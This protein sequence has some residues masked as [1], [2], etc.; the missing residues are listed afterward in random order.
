MNWRQNSKSVLRTG[1]ACGI[2]KYLCTSLAMN[3]AWQAAAL[4]ASTLLAWFKLIALDGRLARTE[5]KTLRYR[6]Y[7]LPPG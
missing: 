1:R 7:A 5:Q 4:T 2:G 3:K 6:T